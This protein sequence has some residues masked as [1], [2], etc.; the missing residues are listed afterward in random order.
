AR[1]AT[2]DRPVRDRDRPTQQPLRPAWPGQLAPTS[3]KSP[4]R[5]TAG[6][7]PFLRPRRPPC[8]CP[9][10][11]L[12]EGRL[13]AAGRIVSRPGL[14]GPS[15][16]PARAGRRL[17][18]LSRGWCGMNRTGMAVAVGL[19]AFLGGLAGVGLFCR[20]LPALRAQAPGRGEADAA[21]RLSER[22]EE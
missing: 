19:G 13:R 20:G 5:R 11:A 14:W 18:L 17:R 22:F 21:L 16:R 3:G 15:P 4:R 1:R 7:V 10:R 6:F 2:R 9:P 8:A 12:S